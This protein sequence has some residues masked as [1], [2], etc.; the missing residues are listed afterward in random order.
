MGCKSALWTVYFILTIIAGIG[1]WLLVL[2]QESR[3]V[4][5]EETSR[6][7]DLL[8]REIEAHKRT[9]AKLQR[10]KEVAEAANEAKSRHLV[11]LSHELR[12]P[13]NSIFGYAQVLERDPNIP[14]KRTDAV[15]VIRRSAEHLS[16]LIDG[17]LDISKIEAGRFHLDRNEVRTKEFLDQLLGMFQ[18]QASA[19]GIAFHFTLPERLPFVVHTDENRLRQILIN[20][21]SNAIKFTDE[22]QVTFEMTYRNQV[23]EFIVTD[24]GIGIHAEDLDRIF[25]PFERAAPR[26]TER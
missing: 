23:A 4:A 5:E 6:Q 10:A 25:L 9:D 21:L 16:G 13:L 14:A 20:L 11:G 12:T 17:L 19:R 3:R 2:A 22:G 8:M 1:A 7:T 15:K 24:T 26:A 18:L